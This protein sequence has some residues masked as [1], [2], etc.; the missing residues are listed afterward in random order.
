[1]AQIFNNIEGFLALLLLTND[2]ESNNM[3]YY[4]REVL[5]WTSRNQPT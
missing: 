3:D 2:I 4:L 1:M 5:T